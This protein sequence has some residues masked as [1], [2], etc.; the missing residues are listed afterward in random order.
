VRPENLTCQLIRETRE[1]GVSIPTRGML[2]AVRIC[3][4]LSGRKADKYL[5]TG[6]TPLKGSRI[7]SSL[8]E[9]CPLKLECRMV[10]ELEHQG[11]HTWFIGELVHVHLDESYR[12]EEALMYWPFQYR[13]VGEVILEERRS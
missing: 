11:S 7:E 1:F 13:A 9:E 5:E 8:V 12:K 4:R 3:G 6:L 2:E 10:H